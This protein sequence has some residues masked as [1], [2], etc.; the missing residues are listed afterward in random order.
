MSLQIPRPLR[1]VTRG[2][3]LLLEIAGDQKA[4]AHA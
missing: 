3:A 4:L 1:A 2:A